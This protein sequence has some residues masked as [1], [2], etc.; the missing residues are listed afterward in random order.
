[1]GRIAE[2][3]LRSSRN[4]LSYDPQVQGQDWLQK[5][6]R[7]TYLLQNLASAMKDPSIINNKPKEDLHLR[8]DVHAPS[9]PI[10]CILSPLGLVSKHDG[11]F[12]QIYHLSHLK[13]RLANNRI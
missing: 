1:M 12:K 2:N 3:L 10:P 8:R 4:L 11:G 5:P 13:R 6:A 9:P 7:H